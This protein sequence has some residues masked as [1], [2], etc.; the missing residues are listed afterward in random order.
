MLL[1]ASCHKMCPAW[2]VFIMLSY[3]WRGSTMF[4]QQTHDSEFLATCQALLLSTM[5]GRSSI[6]ITL[7]L[8]CLH[9]VSSNV[10]YLAVP[11]D[12]IVPTPTINKFARPWH[13]RSF[14][15]VQATHTPSVLLLV[16]CVHTLLPQAVKFCSAACHKRA[17]KHGHK[18]ACA[19]LKQRQAAAQ[20]SA[21]HEGE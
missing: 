17:W 12:P 21:A 5:R 9:S 19:L 10:L 8:F 3:T 6:G 2:H 11:Y 20:A 4:V 18:A 13:H 15:T 1:V 7:L 16:S 14:L